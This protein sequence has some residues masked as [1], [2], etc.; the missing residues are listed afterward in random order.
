MRNR[1][2]AL[3]RLSIVLGATLVLGAPAAFAAAPSVPPAPTVAADA[4]GTH[5]AALSPA[6]EAQ[7][8]KRLDAMLGDT[9]TKVPGLGVVLYRNGQ[10]VYSHFAGS[11]CFLTQDGTAAEPITRDTRF[12][13]ASVSKQF[14]I[15]TLMQLVEA[16]KLSLDDD[17]SRYLGFSLRSPAHPDMPI[18]VRMLASHTSSLRDG[19]VY[20]IPPSISVREFFTT[21]G[22]YYENGDH[23]APA[24]EGPGSYFC[25]AN[26]N[27]GL[28]G[29]I[30]E[31]VTGERFDLYQKKH[32]LKELDT[33]ADYVP[34]NLA[35]R[36]F[37]KLG[38]IYQ[39]KDESGHWDEF[40]RWYGK[41]DDYGGQQPKKDS[42]YLQNPY[43]EDI[44]GWFPLKG[45]VPGTNA[46]M[47]S[48]QGGLRIS[49]EE[50]THCLEMLMNGGSYHGRQILSPISIAEMLRPQW[51]Y[52]AAQKNGSTGG[53][54]LLSYGLGEVQ[55]AGNSTSRV[56]RAHEVDL[57]GH[58]GEA[59]GL[60]SGVFFRPG[61]KDGFVYIMNGEAVAEDDD[62]RSAGT[63]SGNY[64]WEE[65][66]MDALTEA[67][68]SER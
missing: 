62:P 18:T 49:Y 25:Y 33:H 52:D 44:Q 66:I 51:Q 17:V 68:L 28:L 19:K 59:F 34:G 9:G 50:L 47:L 29:T 60:L 48:P 56:N 23:F 16:G 22:R 39:K 36:D 3:R 10:E 43:A 15:F 1:M 20:S 46:T 32:I 38:T 65:E 35:K 41:A 7:L 55:I 4:S 54:T 53:G 30:I 26:I 63:F 5:S 8:T 40:G 37:A 31:A 61:T 13:I 6:A 42:I 12:R 67:L 57:V 2:N 24:E 58:N 21:E 27:Y 14:T 64:I 11:R 45:Y